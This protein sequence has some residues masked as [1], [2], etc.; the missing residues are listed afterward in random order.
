MRKLILMLAAALFVLGA[1]RASA[2]SNTP[3]IGGYCPVAY[4]AMGKAVKGDPDV[5]ADYAGHHYLFVN[6]NAKKMF[7]ADPS[8]YAVA[9]DGY[10]ATAMAMGKEV[11]SNPTLFS[12]SNGVTYLFST[13]QAKKMFDADP[14]GTIK[15]ADQHWAGLK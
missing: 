6:A 15:K 1:D 10:C 3:A 11:E 14:A 8:K 7:E 5:S 4:V 12:R 13:E 2:D 9:Y